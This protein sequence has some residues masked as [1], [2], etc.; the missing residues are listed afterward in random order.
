MVLEN[1]LLIKANL[2]GIEIIK[3]SHGAIRQLY[4]FEKTTEL[5]KIRAVLSQNI[6]VNFPLSVK[7][8]VMMGR[9]PHFTN[10]PSKKM[11]LLVKKP[12][13]FLI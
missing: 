12:F 3:S 10:F 8:I 5:A 4:F 7:E 6:E 11:K 9:Y 1:Q 2:W 13:L